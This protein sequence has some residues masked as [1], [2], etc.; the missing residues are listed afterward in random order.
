MLD[1]G[2]DPV[3]WLRARGIGANA[4]TADY[5]DGAT[6]AMIER[7]IDAGIERI[8]TNTAPAW[9][10]AFSTSEAGTHG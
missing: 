7:L 5:P 6:V 4:W 2:F 1:D 3:A 8:T 10:A 9:V